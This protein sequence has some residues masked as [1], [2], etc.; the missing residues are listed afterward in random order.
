MPGARFSCPISAG[1]RFDPTNALVES[2]SLIRVATTRTWQESDP[3]NGSI[4]GNASCDLKV[5]VDV[6]LIG[7]DGMTNAA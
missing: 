6:D 4:F 2:A 3:M 5:A 7:D 1:W